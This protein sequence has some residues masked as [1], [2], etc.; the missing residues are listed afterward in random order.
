MIVIVFQEN[1]WQPKSQ[2][3]KFVLCMKNSNP[4]PHSVFLRVNPG[5]DGNARLSSGLLGMHLLGELTSHSRLGG[6]LLALIGSRKRPTSAQRVVGTSV[7]RRTGCTSSAPSLDKT[8]LTVC[9]PSRVNLRESISRIFRVESLLV[10]SKRPVLIRSLPYG[11][12][13]G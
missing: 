7:G 13:R 3:D 1:R 12:I 10:N 9:L 5:V 2:V 8:S 6:I 11:T 4:Y